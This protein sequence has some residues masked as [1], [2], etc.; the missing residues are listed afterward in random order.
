M[1]PVFFGFVL[2]FAMVVYKALERL[3]FALVPGFFPLPPLPLLVA[4]SLPAAGLPWFMAIFGRDSIFTSLQALP[5]APELASTT[6]KALAS[7]Q[8]SRVD[9]FRDE[10]PGKILH[11]TRGGEMAAL[12]VVRAAIIS[13]GAAPIAAAATATLAAHASPEPGRRRAASCPANRAPPPAAIR[14]VEAA[15]PRV[16]CLFC[17]PTVMAVPWAR[18][19]ARHT[20]QFDQQVAW[21]ARFAPRTVVAELM[22]IAWETVGSIVSRVMAEAIVANDNRFDGVRRIEH[23]RRGVEIHVRHREPHALALPAADVVGVDLADRR[24]R[25]EQRRQPLFAVFVRGLGARAQ[26][27]EA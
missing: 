1:L 16:D 6:L 12:G 4:A 25:G 19:N 14:A 21:L 11:E 9:D 27:R 8:G 15:A 17:G 22:R 3:K 26:R 10:E 20:L 24:A 23:R 18:H 13:A 5:F 2:G 7:W